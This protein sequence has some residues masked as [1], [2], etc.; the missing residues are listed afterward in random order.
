MFKPLDDCKHGIF[1]N[2]WPLYKEITTPYRG[3]VQ[4]I[5]PTTAI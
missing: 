1:M 4:S 5:S 3:S 2:Y